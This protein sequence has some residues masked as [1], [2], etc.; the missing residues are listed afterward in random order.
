MTDEYASLREAILKP[1]ARK[2][3][4]WGFLQYCIALGA[5]EVASRTVR[6][7]RKTTG[8]AVDRNYDR[9]HHVD[10]TG[11]ISAKYLSVDTSFRDHSAQYV[12]VAQKSFRCML[13]AVPVDLRKYTFVDYGSG[14][15]RALLLAAERPFRRAVGVEYS[16]LLKRIADSNITR[17][18]NGVLQCGSIETLLMDA[19]QF[20]P[21]S[22]PCLFFFFAPFDD[23]LLD[24]VLKRVKAS[25]SR[26]PRPMVIL[27]CE[28]KGYPMPTELIEGMGFMQSVGVPSLPFDLGAPIPTIF[29][30]YANSEAL[31]LA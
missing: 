13:D 6:L 27:Y 20:E 28:E 16:E 17:Y 19:T 8:I 2:G 10:T 14:K 11:R 30:I 12:P 15:G 22:G 29:A 31:E 3:G 5:R 23:E 7:V 1:I 4:V 18:R 25:Y 9:R 21:P 26:D 24:R